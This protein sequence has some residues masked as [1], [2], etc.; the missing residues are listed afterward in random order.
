[1]TI[2]K[3]QY[4]VM[5][6]EPTWDM[7]Y[8]GMQTPNTA[9]DAF[10]KTCYMNMIKVKPPTSLK[11]VTEEEWGALVAALNKFIDEAEEVDLG[12]GDAVVTTCESLEA[13]RAAITTAT[14]EAT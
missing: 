9:D 3:D 10:V 2:D 8:E 4:V 6:I 13:A 5:P 7:I 11:I 14:Q 1:M 12:G